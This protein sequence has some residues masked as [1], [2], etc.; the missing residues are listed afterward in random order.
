MGHLER[1]GLAH[2][3]DE[4]RFNAA[5]RTTLPEGR[6]YRYLCIG[7]DRFHGQVLGPVLA[8]A[9]ARRDAARGITTVAALR[10]RT[11]MI[12]ELSASKV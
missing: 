1:M 4:D 9:C 12:N 5:S 2:G 7:R 11:V 3:W 6:P 10:R 8:E